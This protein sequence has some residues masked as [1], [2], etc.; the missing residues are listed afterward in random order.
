M[1]KKVLIPLTLILTLLAF[2]NPNKSEFVSWGQK[3]F[4]DSVDNSFLKWGASLIGK[5]YIENVSNAHNYVFFSFY[6][7]PIGNEKT[8]ILGVFNNFIPISSTANAQPTLK[9]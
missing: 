4:V 3:R 2:T 8:K 9:Y 1:G 6:E 5:S 7:L